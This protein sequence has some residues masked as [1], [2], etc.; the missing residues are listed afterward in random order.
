MLRNRVRLC[1]N[2][3]YHYGIQHIRTSPH[4]ISQHFTTYCNILQHDFTTWFYNILPWF[5]MHITS[6]LQHITCMLRNVHCEIDVKCN[7]LQYVYCNIIVKY[8]ILQYAVMYTQYET[9]QFTIIFTQVCVMLVLLM[10][11]ET[12]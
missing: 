4:K 9:H 8:I 12:T 1:P 6:I 7:G 11:A 2:V 10:L 5:Y 3:L